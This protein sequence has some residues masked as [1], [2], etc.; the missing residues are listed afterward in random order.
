MRLLLAPAQKTVRIF[1]VTVSFAVLVCFAVP[2]CAQQAV[3]TVGQAIKHDTSLP[4]R[5][6]THK[7]TLSGDKKTIGPIRDKPHFGRS[8]DN[9]AP[10]GGLQSSSVLK[11]AL[12]TTPQP[13]LSVKGLSGDDNIDLNGYSVVPPDTNG[14]I[15]LDESGNRVYVQYINSVWGVF[16][17]TTGSL[18]N[19]PFLHNSFWQGFGGPCDQGG[20]PLTYPMVLYDDRARRWVFSIAAVSAGTQ[21][22]AVSTTS[23]PLGPYHRYAFTVT[24]GGHND[25]ALLGVWDDGTSGSAG[26]SAYSIT[27]RDFG[28]AGGYFSVGATL[29]ERDAMLNGEA[30]QFIK[31]SNPCAG[32]DCVEGQLPPH[33]AGPPPPVGTCPTFWAAVDEAFDASPHAI[34]GYR[35]HTLCVDWANLNNSTYTE[36][37]FVVAGS[38]FDRFLGDIGP[39]AGSENLDSHVNFTMYRAQY[40]WFGNHAS[41]VL[42]TTVD[43]G[44]DRAGIRWAELRSLDGDSGWFR[45][46]GGTYA[47]DD[48]NERWMGSIAQ[49]ES[50][51]IALGYSIASPI[52]LPGVRYTSRLAGDE[53]GTMPGGEASCHEG[54]T[55]QIDSSGRWGNYSSMSVDPI[56]GCTFWYTQEYAENIGSFTF[57]TRICSFK[58]S[59]CQAWSYK[60]SFEDIPPVCEPLAVEACYEGPPDLLGVGIC[61]AGSRTC[62]VVG[63]WGSCSGIGPVGEV[64]GDGL[65]NDCNG[66]TDDGF[67]CA[68]AACDPL[69]SDGTCSAGLGCYIDSC[70][71]NNCNAACDTAGRGQAGF[72]CLVNSDCGSGMQCWD[73]VCLL[74]C[75]PEDQFACSRGSSCVLTGVTVDGQKIGACRLD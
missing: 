62:D 64:C 51:N 14:D 31:F 27:T 53:A 12:G 55:G 3:K 33:Q 4:L 65:D 40:R 61:A 7:K 60:D 25:Y 47:P 10:D 35:N 68:G 58:L 72:A 63:Q 17:A 45:Q 57:N 6:F 48:G 50:G 19:G 21:C 43:A 56:D 24:P 59:D 66:A 2:V 9:A 8:A 16:N 71:N 52:L 39:I 32:D 11:G 18:T 54:T 49:D 22:V 41:V 20:I 30:A 37:P 70:N 44:D 5:K 69:D 29:L 34:D 36:G 75:D 13:I 67:G 28:G 26:Q 1:G 38:N 23:D 73:G 42:N 46:Q 74:S 15:G